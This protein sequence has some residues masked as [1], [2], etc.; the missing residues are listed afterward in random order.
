MAAVYTSGSLVLA[1]QPQQK[2]IP[3]DGH[4]NKRRPARKPGPALLYLFLL[5]VGVS[6]SETIATKA[7]LV[8]APT[9]AHILE[10]S[11]SF[12]VLFPV[13]GSGLSASTTPPSTFSLSAW[14]STSSPTL[15]GPGSGRT[16]AIRSS[17]SPLPQRACRSS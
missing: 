2:R 14:S 16:A 9:K 8:G 12:R 7:A 10:V 4:Q 15:G 13:S 17:T 6:S 5:L 3:K 1:E 11:V